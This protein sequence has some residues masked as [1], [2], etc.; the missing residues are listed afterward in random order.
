MTLMV[1]RAVKPEHIIIIII[2]LIQ[3]AQVCQYFSKSFFICSYFTAE[4]ILMLTLRVKISAD[5]IL[6]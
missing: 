6:K 4:I 2:I 3:A 5:N 1:W